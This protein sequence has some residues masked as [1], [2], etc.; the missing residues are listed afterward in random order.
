MKS[1]AKIVVSITHAVVIPVVCSLP[2]LL[3]VHK[4]IERDSG[5]YSAVVAER[6]I[7]QQ[8]ATQTVAQASPAA[9][10][11]DAEASPAAQATVVYGGIHN[12]AKEN[13]GLR[14]VQEPAP[15]TL[16]APAI[17]IPNASAPPVHGSDEPPPRY[18]NYY[19]PAPENQPN[20]YPQNVQP[21]PAND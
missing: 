8:S 19:A 3:V 16:S 9:Q 12:V 18:P 5:R 20:P 13:G 6:E 1:L 7:G 14:P 21:A 10:A 4:K 17:N 15:G 2:L 11:T